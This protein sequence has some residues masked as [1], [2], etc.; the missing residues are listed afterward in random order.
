M[1][2]CYWRV[3]RMRENAKYKRVTDEL[4]HAGPEGEKP[5]AAAPNA[6]QGYDWQCVCMVAVLDPYW[7]NQRNHHN[8][9][10]IHIASC[11]VMCWC[12]ITR[13]LKHS[14]LRLMGRFFWPR[15][16]ASMFGWFLNDF[17]FYVRLG[18]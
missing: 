14:N 17:G 15:M 5:V 12:C 18:V 6:K 16:I 10:H 1:V 13:P 2:L 8:P 11:M 4:N 7:R 3:F 9:I